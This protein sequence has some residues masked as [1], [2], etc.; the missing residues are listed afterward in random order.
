MNYI[1]SIAERL[2]AALPGCPEDLIRLYAL[3][4]RVKGA[5]TTDEDVHDAWSAWQMVSDPAH[6]SLIPFD[7]L[8]PEVQ[9]LDTKY[10]Q[11]IRAVA[12]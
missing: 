1:A 12:A 6:R 11:A 8:T 5:D 10:A 9:A 4:V 2:A 7:E 3:L